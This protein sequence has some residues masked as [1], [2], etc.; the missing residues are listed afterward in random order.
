MNCCIVHVDHVDRYWRV[1]N[2]VRDR[3][4]VTTYRLFP[5]SYRV[6]SRV[7]VRI[8]VQYVNVD[9]GWDKKRPERL[10]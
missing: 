3:C 6:V 7:I 4:R 5:W 2:Y 10:W 8:R 9:G 1:S